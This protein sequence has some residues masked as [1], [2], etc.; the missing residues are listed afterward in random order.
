MINQS[1]GPYIHYVCPKCG[2][3]I[4][5][6]DYK[7]DDPIKFDESIYTVRSIDNESSLDNLKIFSKISGLN[8]VKCKELIENDGVICSGK[9]SDIIDNLKE[10]KANKIQFEISPFFKYDI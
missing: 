10:L 4:A 7:K 2:N 3:A 6:Y 1:K 8:Y 5:T 9:A